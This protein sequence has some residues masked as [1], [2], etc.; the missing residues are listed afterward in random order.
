MEAVGSSK[1]LVS[2]Y[3]TV[4]TKVIEGNCLQDK[5]Y[6]KNE[7]SKERIQNKDVSLSL[8]KLV[9]LI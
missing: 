4:W 5:L 9:R 2:I 6:S 7:K 1:T 8:E 3:Q